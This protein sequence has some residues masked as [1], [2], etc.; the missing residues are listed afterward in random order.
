MRYRA[1]N[2]GRSTVACEMSKMLVYERA[3]N[4]CEVC[5]SHESLSVH[6]VIPVR[7]APYLIDDPDNQKL[8]CA[9]CH[10]EADRLCEEE[11]GSS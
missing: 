11:Y 7:V 4:K 1:K 10:I 2:P 6:H 9:K 3:Q 5:G 8:L